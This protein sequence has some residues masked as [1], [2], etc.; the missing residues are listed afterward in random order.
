MEEGKVVLLENIVNNVA[1]TVTK[2]SQAQFDPA[3]Y[4]FTVLCLCDQVEKRY[5]QQGL[6]PFPHSTN[7][8][9]GGEG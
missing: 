4:L 8:G 6:S 5:G 7:A 3:R 2:D 1:E 9:G